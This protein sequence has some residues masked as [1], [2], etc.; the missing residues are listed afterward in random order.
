M[1]D[2]YANSA[3]N[4]ATT[5]STNS[6]GG[7]YRERQFRDVQPKNLTV[8]L[9]TQEEEKCY[10]F[11]GLYWNFQVTN[12]PLHRRGWVFQE[13]ILAPR[14]FYF[15]K[16]QILW[17]C[18]KERKCEAFPQDIPL[19]RSLKKLEVLSC[20]ADPNTDTNSP[21]SRDAFGFWNQ[22]VDGYSQCGL[23]RSN[24]KLI[25]LSGIAHLFQ[26]A[27]GEEYIAGLWKSRL[28]ESLDWRVYR[29]RAKVPSSYHAPSWFWASIDG[30][31]YPCGI[32]TG[33][34]YLI[35]ILDTEVSNSKIDP[36]GQVYSGFV[37][38]KGFL[39]ETIYH[40]L[41]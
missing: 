1:R 37:V 33:S 18:F 39:I 22:I 25:A 21:L 7:L 31:V 9:L 40:T 12:A 32:T 16:D 34:T 29:P 10:V 24:D 6:E 36:L 35:D 23:T 26:A 3:C 38:V 4:I 2:V 15:G 19:L 41:D 13:C 30:P 11:E 17:E 28:K 14:I 27:I 5:A 20:P 8:S